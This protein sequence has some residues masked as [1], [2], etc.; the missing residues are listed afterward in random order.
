MAGSDEDMAMIGNKRPGVA[1]CFRISKDITESLDKLITVPVVPKNLTLLVT[2]NDDVVK[3][4]RSI[5][6]CFTW[7]AFS[8]VPQKISVNLFINLGTSPLFVF[9]EKIIDLSGFFVSSI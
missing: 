1:G 3:C 8:L 6:A 2:P 7:H 4:T 5:D 9:F